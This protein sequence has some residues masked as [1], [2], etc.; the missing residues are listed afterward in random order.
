MKENLIRRK[1]E[2]IE[3]RFQALHGQSSIEH[4]ANMIGR[5]NKVVPGCYCHACSMASFIQPK[6]GLDST[7]ETRTEDENDTA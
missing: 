1:A 7:Q 5:K 3:K 4:L 2:T 6:D